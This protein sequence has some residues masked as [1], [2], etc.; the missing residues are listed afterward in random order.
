MPRVDIA[1]DAIT[2][3]GEPALIQAGALHYFR[4]PHRA[5]WRPLLE[6]LRVGGLNAVWI[7]FPWAYHSPAAGFYD[8]TGPRDIRYLLDEVERVGLWL[9]PHVGPWVGLGLG[10]GGVPVWALQTP[11]LAPACDDPAR[12]GPSPPFLRH[13]ASWWERLF[14]AFVER[15]NLL[16]VALDPGRCALGAAAG[17]LQRYLAPL[18]ALA[19]QIGGDLRCLVPDGPGLDVA[20]PGDELHGV[21][22]MRAVVAEAVSAAPAPL[23][24]SARAVWVD[25]AR[26]PTWGGGTVAPLQRVTGE[27]YPRLALAK[28]YGDGAR[29]TVVSPA[30]TGVNWAWWGAV[31]A[32]TLAGYGA[33]LAGS[34]ERLPAYYRMRRMLLTAES[35]GPILAEG[36]SDPDVHTLPPQARL[37]ARTHATGTAA[38][39][40]GTPGAG[41]TAHLV[42]GSGHDAARVEDIALAQD[43]VTVLPVAWQLAEGR[44]L[45]TTLEPVLHTVVAGRELLIVC[46]EAGGEV[47][48]SADYRA[49]G[50]RG[51]V[52]V[53]RVPEG[54][55]LHFD[56]ARL[57]SLVLDGP[58]GILQVLALEPSMAER[59]WPLDDAWRKT[60]CPP[61]AW[62][63]AD[64]DPARGVVIG[65]DLVVPRS[66]GSFRFLAGGRG[67][68]YR[69]G[70]WRGSDPNTWLSPITWKGPEPPGLPSLVWQ[71]RPGAPEALPAY[72]DRGWRR[73]PPGADLAMEAQGV[74]HGFIWYRGYVTGSPS[75]VTLTC[76][77]ACDLFVNGAHVAAL[78]PPPD[79]GPVAPKTLPV[80]PRHL[81]TQR[82][83]E[84]AAPSHNVIALLVENLGREETWDR[85]PDLHGLITCEVEGAEIVTWRV[86]EGLSGETRVQGF[87]GCANWDLIEEGGSAAV[88]WHRAGFRL[89]LPDDVE[90]PLFLVLDQTPGKGYVYL[91][92]TLIG[93]L[94]YPQEPQRRFW[95]PDGLL[96]R[97]GSNELLIAQWTRGADPGIGI[98]RL[99]AG[100][101][102]VWHTESGGR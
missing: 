66:D 90:M 75:A 88:T 93:R 74:S 40:T 19:R 91:N 44:L 84:A 2:I 102:R 98:A 20:A 42:L 50:R 5:L 71:S 26:T 56:P 22:P 36:R 57:A 79:F 3:D 18:V 30:H 86:R 89:D 9:I 51:P 17:S 73:V 16:L 61:A 38:L 58:S 46:N 76:R 85:A 43:A 6:R 25:L 62:N 48:L 69:W 94:W 1:S 96:Q 60:P 45:D 28:V 70:P 8:F 87:Y 80:S 65:P 24:G 41:G 63:P 7:P 59:V 81:Q 54:L 78:N 37:A 12:T 15:P 39:L 23:Q 33:P 27:V 4:L 14:P 53:E 68:G 64:E 29:M 10:G 31:G 77:H 67:F 55:S 82:P 99:E 95:L 11:D 32:G 49:R 35:L 13:V 83:G 97:Q 92:G 72:D 21:I 34:G 101:P 47:R 100:P 52:Y